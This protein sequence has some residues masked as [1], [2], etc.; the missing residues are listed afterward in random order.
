MT[1]DIDHDNGEAATDQLTLAVSQWLT[2]A[3][4]ALPQAQL[5]LLNRAIL[6]P[7]L[8]VSVR[9]QL[10]AGRLTLEVSDGVAKTDLTAV[11]V[12]PLH[13]APLH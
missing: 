11:H 2:A 5:D 13:M 6:D 3:A 7:E 4:Q 12:E 8:E 9:A 10:K 1:T